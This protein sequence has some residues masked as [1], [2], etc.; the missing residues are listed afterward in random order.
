M[1]KIIVKGPPE[2]LKRRGANKIQWTICRHTD[3][4]IKGGR[5]EALEVR[6]KGTKRW[7]NSTTGVAAKH[8]DKLF[9]SF[10]EKES[11]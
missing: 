5:Q 10:Y 8:T 3:T 9:W 6:V 7:G 1:R 4:V 11:P 2:T